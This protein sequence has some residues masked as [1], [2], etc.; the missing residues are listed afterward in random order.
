MYMS[1]TQNST[2]NVLLVHVHAPVDAVLKAHYLTLQCT[3][4]VNFL[5]C[6]AVGSPRGSRACRIIWGP[7]AK[8]RSRGTG[9]TAVLSQDIAF[10]IYTHTHMHTHTH[11]HTHTHIRT[12][13]HAHNNTYTG[14]HSIYVHIVYSTPFSYYIV[15][16]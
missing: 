12:R 1:L 14:T 10:M 3:R 5:L 13:T 9:E 7:R 15:T 4:C 6:C 2:F 16:T 11:T 8:G